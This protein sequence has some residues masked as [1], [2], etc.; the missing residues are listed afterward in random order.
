M[1][2]R[3]L[4]EFGFPLMLPWMTKDS[5]QS[6]MSLTK[7]MISKHSNVHIQSIQNWNHLF[8]S[9]HTT[10]C[11]KNY[12]IRYYNLAFSGRSLEGS[13]ILSSQP[14]FSLDPIIPT[15]SVGSSWSQS[16]SPLPKWKLHVIFTANP[17]TIRFNYRQSFLS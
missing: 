4:A 17:N 6:F 13:S 8:T 3:G 10:H 15:V 16:L 9:S 7:I 11:K 1:N 14:N 5:K 12:T 2:L